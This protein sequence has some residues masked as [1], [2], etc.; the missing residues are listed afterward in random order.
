MSSFWRKVAAICVAA[1]AIAASVAVATAATGGNGNSPSRV[2]KAAVPAGPDEHLSALAKELGVS[3]SKLRDALDDVRQKLEPPKRPSGRP[4]RAQLEKRCNEM[5][6]ALASE[7]GKSGDEVRAAT[8]KVMKAEIEDAVKDKRLTRS[9]ADKILDR[10][11]DAACLPAFGPGPG[12]HCG[13]PPGAR[14]GSGSGDS[15]IPAPQSG[16]PAMEFAPAA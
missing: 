4:S 6:D 13:P 10:L 16:G 11:D 8:K 5:T 12:G 2:G 15:A 9:Q 14:R 7:L 3:S 1:A